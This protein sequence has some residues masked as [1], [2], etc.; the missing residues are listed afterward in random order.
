MDARKIALV[1]VLSALG[2]V[3]SAIS[4]GVVPIVPNVAL[5]LSHVATFVAAIFGGPLMGAAVGFFGGIYAG[6]YFGF[7]SSSG[8]GFLSLIGV[9]L[10]KAMTG[11]F[12]GFLYKRLKLGTESGR[13][14]YAIPATLL[15][16]VPESIY[17]ALYFLYI[18][19]WINLAPMSFMIMLVIPKGW[20]EITVM[21]VL[22]AALAG[23]K[24]FIEFINRFFIQQKTRRSIPDTL[25]R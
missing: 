18:V 6:Y 13:S 25:S 5:D 22:I 3:L 7:G 15:A 21:S 12:A 14:V 24:G 19:T 8:L 10:G 1:A 2:T 4:L 9:P 20:L 11:L 16:Y 17:T 23:N